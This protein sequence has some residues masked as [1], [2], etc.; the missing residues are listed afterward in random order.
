MVRDLVGCQDAEGDV[1]LAAP[2]DLPGGP[3]A[4]AVAVQQHAQQ[5]LGVIGGMPVTVVAVGPVKGFEVELVD[6]VEDEPGEMILGEP[7]AQVRGQQEGLVAL[8]AQEVVSHGLFY[9]STAFAPNP[10]LLISLSRN[11]STGGP[12]PDFYPFRVVQLGP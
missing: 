2:F 11:P 4:R 10:L 7:V 5:S 8:C 1:L 3:Y 6:H 9:A 12:N